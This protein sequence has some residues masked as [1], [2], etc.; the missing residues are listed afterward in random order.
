MIYTGDNPQDIRLNNEISCQ[1]L[2]K[3]VPQ[4]LREVEE[5]ASKRKVMGKWIYAP[6]ELEQK[7]EGYK[8]LNEYFE[9]YLSNTP[10]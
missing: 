5:I 1:Q 7:M 9:L 10:S 8:L 2:V 4:F 3:G 6:K